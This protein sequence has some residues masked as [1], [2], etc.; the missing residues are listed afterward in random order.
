METS[1]SVMHF[2]VDSRKWPVSAAR[3][4]EDCVIKSLVWMW[5][6]VCFG[7]T[8]MMLVAMSS[9]LLFLVSCESKLILVKFR[10]VENRVDGLLREARWSDPATDVTYLDNVGRIPVQVYGGGRLGVGV[11]VTSEPAL[12]E[13]LVR[14]IFSE[15]T[16]MFGSSVSSF[17]HKL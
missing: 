12:R 8:R 4:Y 6:G 2:L 11:R 13:I 17:L 15:P 5:N 10:G 7:P 16:L 3:K 1:S 9:D 14:V